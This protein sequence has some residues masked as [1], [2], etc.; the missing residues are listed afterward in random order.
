MFPVNKLRYLCLVL[1][2]LMLS[3]LAQAQPA[4]VKHEVKKGECLTDILRL[5]HKL[6]S[7]Y[8]KGAYLEQTIN[9]NKGKIFKNGDLIFPGTILSIPTGAF[10]RRVAGDDST[11]PL[12]ENV[13]NQDPRPAPQQQL[14]PKDEHE[15]YSN[16]EISVGMSYFALY[17]LQPSNQTT[18]SLFSD[19]SPKLGA[20]WR[21]V[22]SEDI[23]S[24]MFVDLQ[25]V[26]MVNAQGGAVISSPTMLSSDFGLGVDLNLTGR[27][28]FGLEVALAQTLFYEGTSAGDI[29]VQQVPLLRVHPQL[30]YVILKRQKFEVS[31]RG[32]V[33]DYSASSYDKYS[34]QRGNGTDLE[35]QLSQKLNNQEFRC[36]LNYG[37]RHQNTTYLNLV[38][39]NI[40]FGC[41]L[42]WSSLMNET[43]EGSK[44]E[45]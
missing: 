42:S 44:N 6:K 39:K 21:Q 16:F 5:R 33:S 30:Q 7:I 22:W 3:G 32:G 31:V 9:L 35:F 10:N 24:R 18:A 12:M 15:L 4:Y 26:H 34:I 19:V 2:V 23:S 1:A 36:I 38:E 17:G 29:M 28:S 43:I 41:N 20:S 14:A 37:E 11:A 25:S 13:P 40:G 27:L 8:G 45:R